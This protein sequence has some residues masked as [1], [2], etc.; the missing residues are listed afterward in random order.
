MDIASTT[1]PPEDEHDYTGLIFIMSLYAAT[2]MCGLCAS[3]A[4]A[5]ETSDITR[6]A[7]RQQQ[8][9]VKPPAA[10]PV[11]DLPAYHQLRAPV[12]SSEAAAGHP[13]AAAAPAALPVDDLPK[14]HQLPL[15]NDAPPYH[16]P[17]LPVEL[18]C[19]VSVV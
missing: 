7:E 3:S 10:P 18:E 8:A 5:F 6:D 19:V 16:R 15:L 4:R 14:Y 12:V 1:P 13:E 11:D 2:I 17:F 9:P